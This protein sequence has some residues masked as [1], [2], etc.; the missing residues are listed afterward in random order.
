MVCIIAASVVYAPQVI[1]PFSL[2]N[3]LANAIELRVDEVL[4]TNTIGQKHSLLK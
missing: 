3:F 2:A 1:A 4:I